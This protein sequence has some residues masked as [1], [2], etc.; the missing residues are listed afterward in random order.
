MAK[1]LAGSTA[2]WNARLLM[3]P[4]TYAR[5]LRTKSLLHGCRLLRSFSRAAKAC[6]VPTCANNQIP[7]TF[8]LPNAFL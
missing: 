8:E 2:D 4:V 1:G 3:P 7:A 5:T 6:L